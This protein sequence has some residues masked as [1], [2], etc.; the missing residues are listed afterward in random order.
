[1]RLTQIEQLAVTTE[2]PL[3][4]KDYKSLKGLDMRVY[5]V[6]DMPEYRFVIEGL[7]EVLKNNTVRKVL[8][9]VS[10]SLP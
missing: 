6:M 10:D 7:L 4:L 9:Q 5:Q 8:K 2:D 1:M 3:I